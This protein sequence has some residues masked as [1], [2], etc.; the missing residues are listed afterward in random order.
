ML[1][2]HPIAAGVAPA[3]R[4]DQDLVPT[5][6]HAAQ[7]CQQ[8]VEITAQGGEHPATGVAFAE[9]ISTHR[10]ASEAAIRVM[11]RRPW[12]AI[13]TAASELSSSRAASSEAST[14]GVCEMTATAWSCSSAGITTGSARAARTNSCT[15]SSVSGAA[16]ACAAITQGRSSMRSARAAAGPDSS[17]PAIGCPPV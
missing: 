7:C 9:R 5:L 15:A 8:R 3:Q 16:A 10:S 1:A 6:L 2:R 12:P 17:R 14:C 4:V 13:E 11:S